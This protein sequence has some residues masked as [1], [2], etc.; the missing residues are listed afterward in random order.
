MYPHLAGGIPDIRRE[1][2]SADTADA[3]VYFRRQEN[4]SARR[5]RVMYF[6]KF[7]GLMQQPEE[8]GPVTFA[9]P[10]TPGGGFEES[11]T[12]GVA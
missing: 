2:E 10:A 11:D 7:S 4:P 1:R 9:V 8:R 3:V 12:G 5:Q 6:E